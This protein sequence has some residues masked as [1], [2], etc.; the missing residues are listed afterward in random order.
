MRA[1]RLIPP[2][3]P[4]LPVRV[5]GPMPLGDAQDPPV[6]A[7]ALA[8]ARE[9]GDLCTLQ[10]VAVRTARIQILIAAAINE[11]LDRCQALGGR[12]TR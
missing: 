7:L 6:D 3:D 2:N 11:A 12:R 9:I 8:A 10:P 5:T 1:R 4:V